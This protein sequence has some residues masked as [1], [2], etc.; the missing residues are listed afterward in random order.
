[1]LRIF[2]E[3]SFEMRK[4]QMYIFIS[5]LKSNRKWKEPL[6]I[7]NYLK[8]DSNLQLFHYLLNYFTN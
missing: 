8:R 2:F 1:M 3:T 4:V 5:N 6:K 7:H